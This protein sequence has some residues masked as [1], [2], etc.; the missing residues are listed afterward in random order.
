MGESRINVDGYRWFE[1]PRDVQNSQ[2]G[3]GGV[4]FL[5]RD[6][7]IN[8]VAERNTPF[9]WLRYSVDDFLGLI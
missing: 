4:G 5:V 8:E 7:L 1:K 9:Q 6:C 2:R 3:E